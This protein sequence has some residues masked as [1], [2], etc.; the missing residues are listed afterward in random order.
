MK[1]ATRKVIALAGAILAMVAMMALAAPGSALADPVLEVAATHRPA[2]GIA[3]DGRA[4]YAIAVTNTGSTA[5]S[6]LPSVTFE[7]PPGLQIVSTD[8]EIDRHF[9]I[10]V[11]A[12]SITPGG[13]SVT[14]DGTE[15]LG[16]LPIG[17]GTEACQE[18]TEEELGEFIPCRPLITV[19]ADSGLGRG[20]TAPTFSAC[21]AGAAACATGTDPTATWLSFDIVDFDNAITDEA[22]N[23]YTQ[24]GG[25]P[26]QIVTPFEFTESLTTKEESPASD[27]KEGEGIPSEQMKDAG[28][29]LPPGLVGDASVAAQCTEAQ[30]ANPSPLCPSDSQVGV[31][32]LY[33]GE[34]AVLEN[35][36]VYNMVPA[37]GQPAEFGFTIEG[38]AWAHLVPKVRSDGDYGVTISGDNITQFV[39]LTGVQVTF[40]GVPADESHDALRH[41]PGCA[42]GCASNLPPKAFL[43]LPTS[44]TGPVSSILH[45]DSWTHPDN[46]VESEVTNAGIDGC[47]SLDFS[48][49]VQARPTTNAAD[50][51]SGLSVD[52]HTPQ[53]ADPEGTAEAHLKDTTVVL[54]EGLVVNPASA[55]GL[56]AC[57]P[58]QINLHDGKPAHCPDASKIGNVEIETPLIDHPLPGAV[59]VATPHDNPFNS[60]IAIY[61]TV[62]DPR[63]GT[64]IKLA[65]EVHLDPRT[66]RVTS[67]VND[68]PQLPFEHFKVNFKTGAGAPLRT[69]SACGTYRTATTLVPYSAPDSGPPAT[70][71]DVYA[72]SQGSN[73]SSCASDE[74]NSP[75]LDA[76]T[77]SPVAGAYSPF[78]VNLR[79][80]DGSQ[81]FSALTLTPPPGLIGKLAGIPAC[82]D[83]A[84]LAAE[85]KSGRQEQASP[86]C[87]AASQIGSVNAGAGA[88]PAPYYAEG[89]AYLGGPYKGAPLSMAVVTPAV[90]GPFDL[91]TIVVRVALRVDPSSAQITAVSDPIPTILQG[92]PLDVRS[93]QVR[94]DRPEFTRNGTSCDPMAVTG[95][96]LSSLGSTTAIGSPFQL[97]E[98]S[99]LGFKPKLGI[100]LK[101]GVKRGAHPAL[102]AVLRMPEGGANIARA[103]V[104]L[105]HSEFLD[106][107]HIGTVCTRVQ[108]AANQCP[109]ASVYGRATAT[110]PLVDYAVSGPV[111]LRSSSNELPDLVMAL[112]GPPSQPIEVDAVGRVDSVNGGIR[113]SFEAIPDVPLSKFVLEMQGGKKGLLQNSTNVCKGKHLATAQFDG[114]NGK[115]SDLSPPLQPKCAKPRKRKTQ[116]HHAAGK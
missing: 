24:A 100:R 43:S 15:A 54:P 47:N 96:L 81:Q 84:L 25:H 86:S 69:P 30:L 104:A 45:A 22:E 61:I 36:A 92:I 63:S 99:G 72:I 101:G 87:P 89:K 115:A 114:Q 48:P 90:A 49:T 27:H 64:V 12:C 111:Y 13:Q 38:L 66:G 3:S 113:A 16:P 98:C 2:S 11:W 21:G 40:W 110:S 116:K 35:Y 8:D 19:Q 75:S 74:P 23:P 17:P 5:T 14:C 41:G 32:N 73:G 20:S 65:G 4:E 102:R 83:A 95:S 10:P 77:V 93:I 9:G 55:N 85:G 106:Q 37:F 94:L 88:G 67:T 1:S 53:N 46:V 70:P 91:G 71:S 108:F 56:G 39:P 59:F 79:R 52:I 80:P 68:A 109:A 105:P 29:D 82:S 33:A 6:S 44:C 26:Y 57:S 34:G 60:L 112:H 51:P 107:S 97:G 42:S 62:D 7:A 18:F 28:V 76:G 103:V 58:A 78:V 50:S 31:V